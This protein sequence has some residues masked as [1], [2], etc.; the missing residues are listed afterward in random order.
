[1]SC[2]ILIVDDSKMTRA[3]VRKLIG[4]CGTHEGEIFE[5]EN[6]VQGLI[7]LVREQIGLVLADLHMPKM[8]GL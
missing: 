6:G 4:M 5:A 8:G 3:M 7:A 1:M 2:N